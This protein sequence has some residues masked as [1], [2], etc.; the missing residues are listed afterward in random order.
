MMRENA[1]VI[2]GQYLDANED[3]PFESVIEK[4]RP[5]KPWE[6]DIDDLS[7]AAWWILTAVGGVRHAQNDVRELLNVGLDR[8]WKKL[9][10]NGAVPQ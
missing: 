4:S 3:I 10:K 1:S 6:L 9:V 8:A 2:S 7:V 5:A